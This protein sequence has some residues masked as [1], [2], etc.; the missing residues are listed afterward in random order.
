MAL[1]AKAKWPQIYLDHFYLDY[2]TPMI[3]Q[4][5]EWFVFLAESYL[6]GGI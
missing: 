1:V 6:P 4:I 3:R 2:L 5:I